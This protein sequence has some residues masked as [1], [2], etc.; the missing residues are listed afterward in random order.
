MAEGRSL[1]DTAG[2]LAPEVLHRLQLY[3]NAYH[4]LS[5][6]YLQGTWRIDND[7]FVVKVPGSGQSLFLQYWELQGDSAH[8]QKVLHGWRSRIEQ[9]LQQAA[10]SINHDF[11]K[12]FAA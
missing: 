8:R 9:F 6:L 4:Q 1:A 3:A 5:S 2:Q 11:P 12:S 7:N 10:S